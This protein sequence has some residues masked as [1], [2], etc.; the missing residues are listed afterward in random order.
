MGRG[1]ADSGAYARRVAPARTWRKAR[2]VPPISTGGFLAILVLLTS[3]YF[4]PRGISWN[5]DT[6]IFL[7]ASMVDRGSL[8]LDPFAHMT[9]DIA[10]A[11][12][13]YYADKAPGLSIAM[14]P[15]YLLLKYTLLAGHSYASLYALPVTMRPDF[16]VRY[17]LAILYAGVPTALLTALLY[18]FFSRLG[19]PD[20]W[21]AVIALTYAFGTFA[22][23][24]TGELFSHQLSAL[25]V[26][27]AFVLLYR[28]RQNELPARAVTLAGLLLGYAIITEY[29]TALIAAALGLYALI[30]S[31]SPRITAARLISGALPAL[32]ICAVYNA[33]TFGSPLSLGYGH[34]DGPRMFR[35]GQAQGFYGI[36]LPHPDAIWQ[37]TFGPYRGIFFLSPFLVLAIP[38]F[39]LLWR[40]AR[41][42]AEW[43]LWLGIVVSYGLFSVSYFEWNGGYSMGPRQFLPAL[44]F[45][46]LPIGGMFT[47]TP[48]I[49]WRVLAL[50]LSI[51]SIVVVELA[52]AVGP[53]VDPAYLSPITQWVLPRLAGM[54]PSPSSA[55]IPSGLS[56]VIFRHA[57]LFLTADLDNNWGMLF[58]LP[59]LAQLV[60]LLFVLGVL[61]IWRW[62]AASRHVTVSGNGARAAP[63]RQSEDDTP[64]RL[65]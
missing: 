60:P 56:A 19:V 16:L 29:P 31:T 50:M 5:S 47:R 22:R 62:Q 42:R 7:T 9:G 8:N 43:M 20:F 14:I 52:T 40:V 27:G 55:L 51:Y 32:L 24:F 25:L 34:L 26:F 53:L 12:G 57:P 3:A 39:V 61:T 46:M 35:T 44:P 45:L 63:L 17:C 33:L 48:R 6:H 54:T 18:G 59:G 4:I 23:A 58:G 28:V 21:R 36:T 65:R 15:A 41:W 38:G 30:G 10:F 1:A 64:A 2:I 13:H 11:H 49:G 37:T